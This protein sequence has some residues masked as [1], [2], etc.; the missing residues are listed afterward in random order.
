M[1]KKVFSG[2]I[3]AGL[4]ASSAFAG[5]PVTI[6]NSANTAA[7]GVTGTSLNVT[8]T[9]GC[10]GGSGS[11]SIVAGNVSNATSGVATTATNVP[12]V[13][14]NYGF[15]TT[16][17][18]QLRTAPNVPT[19]GVGV[20]AAGLVAQFNTTL[21]VMANG[22]YGVL[23][24]DASGNLRA[25]IIAGQTTT[26]RAGLSASIGLPLQANSPTVANILGTAPFLFN[27]T[28]NDAAVDV[29]G[30]VAAG[31]GNAAVDIAPTS[32]A[33]AANVPTATAA[34]GSNLIVKGTPGN[35]YSWVVTSAA[36][37]G[38]VMIFNATT[39]PADG[40]VTPADCRVIAANSTIGSGNYDIPER[41]STGIVIGF[42]TTGCFSKASS[43]TA[44]IRATFQ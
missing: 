13:S 22:T 41:Y 9:S 3:I 16:T 32:A 12:T 11:P 30:A 42:S 10:T 19:T 4:L 43:A 44:Y 5:Q 35:L 39:L 36:S 27:G 33:T 38:Y 8:C 34:V 20:L 14:Y 2:S 24:G 1:I 6:Q 37:A 15:G 17:W 21:P 28:T 40:A 25:T 7:A 29:V 26:T 23:Q 31:T 18:D